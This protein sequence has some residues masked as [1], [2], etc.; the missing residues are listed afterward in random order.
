MFTINITNHTINNIW[1]A[2]PSARP[3]GRRQGA[4]VF[5]SKYLEKSTIPNS[6]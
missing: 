2:G 5:H 1:A 4:P 3:G 6:V